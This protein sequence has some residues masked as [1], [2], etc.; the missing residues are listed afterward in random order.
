MGY[1]TYPTSDL[2]YIILK[3]ERIT[4]DQLKVLRI[5]KLVCCSR[6]RE[7]QSKDWG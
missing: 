1:L 7:S 5:E 3:R 6:E 2:L 4:V